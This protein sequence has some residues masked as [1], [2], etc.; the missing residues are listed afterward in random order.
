MFHQTLF[1]V[2]WIQTMLTYCAFLLSACATYMGGQKD[3]LRKIFSG[4]RCTKIS[5]RTMDY[6]WG[7]CKISAG[8][9]FINLF[10]CTVHQPLFLLSYLF[11]IT[12]L[13]ISIYSRISTICL[14]KVRQSE[15]IAPCSS[16]W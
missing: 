6:S 15:Q 8:S 5:C 12:Y 9:V 14:P 11:F 1:C 2:C 16:S 4:A 7:E 3:Q 13:P 10:V